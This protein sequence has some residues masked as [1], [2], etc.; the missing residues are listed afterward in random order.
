MVDHDLVE[1]HLEKSIFLLL[2]WSTFVC[3]N[4]QTQF[5]YCWIGQSN[6]FISTDDAEE[7]I[8]V[9]SY[10]A[11]W[12]NIR[13]FCCQMFRG[14]GIGGWG[15]RGVRI[16]LSFCVLRL[17]ITFLRASWN[18]FCDQKS[19]SLAKSAANLQS[20]LLY[21]AEPSPDSV[22]T[23]CQYLA[24]ESSLD[25]QFLWPETNCNLIWAMI[26]HEFSP[27]LVVNFDIQ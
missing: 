12:E 9:M 3:V 18:K 17:K 8:H 10:T 24:I 1:V 23:R 2:I 20:I 5:S 21:F 27:S 14:S 19:S 6:I 16:W 7:N 26:H 25:P 4:W 13:I 22:L 15:L 11:K